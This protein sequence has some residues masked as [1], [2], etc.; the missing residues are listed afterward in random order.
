MSDLFKG[1]PDV[2]QDLKELAQNVGLVSQDVE[3][4]EQ[5][6]DTHTIQDASTTQKGHVQLSNATNSDSETMASTPKAIKLASELIN[7]RINQALDVGPSVV[8][9][10]LDKK[11]SGW[12]GVTSY[13]GL[14]YVFSDRNEDFQLEN[15]ISVYTLD[16]K[17]V[18]EKR[19]AYTGLDTD[20]KFMS[21]GDANEIDGFI[22]VTAYNINDGG[23]SPYQSKIVKY[24]PSDLSIVQEYAIGGGVAE[25][26][27]KHNGY[28]WVVYHDMY[29]VRQFDLNFTFLMEYTLITGD[30]PHGGYQGSLWD[31]GY[32]YANLHGHNTLSDAQPFSEL[33]KFSFNGT[34]FTH[35]ES[36]DPPTIGCGQGLGKYGDFYLWNDRPDNSIVISKSI[37]KGNVY[38]VTAPIK[39]EMVV[40]LVPVNN[41]T[42]YDVHRPPKAILKDGIVYLTGMVRVPTGFI[43]DGNPIN[44]VLTIPKQMVAY[45]SKNFT[46]ATNK[47]AVRVALAGLMDTNHT[48]KI[49]LGEADYAVDGTTWVALDGINYPLI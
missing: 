17:F 30:A 6:Y 31:D 10:P 44:Y 16:G 3:L 1:M 32:F 22:Y 12:Q 29:V 45:S 28:Y 35:V 39:N 34:E 18:S 21:F 11:Y 33:R 15:I 41:F 23:A 36:I 25:S 26:V 38:P 47:G 7:A 14:L 2:V 20:G 13:D 42:A 37:K 24:N 43:G 5:E 9:I 49:V 46:C 4:L 48:G 27:T 8:K 19:N 40:E